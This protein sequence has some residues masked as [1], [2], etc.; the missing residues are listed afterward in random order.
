[1][2]GIRDYGYNMTAI[3]GSL[4]KLFKAGKL[5]G[6]IA[7]GDKDAEEAVE[8]V[9]GVA[10]MAAGIPNQLNKLFFNAWDI[11]YNDMDAEWRDLFYRRPARDR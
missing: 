10:T 1:M 2:L 4:D 11:L 3:E 9:A 5:V 8:P 6:D 7:D